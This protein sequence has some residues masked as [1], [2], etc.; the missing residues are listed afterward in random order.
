ML[1]M[2][3]FCKAVQ[4]IHITFDVVYNI[5]C[6][7]LAFSATDA[8]VLFKFA[9]ESGTRDLLLGQTVNQHI[10][11]PSRLFQYEGVFCSSTNGIISWLKCRTLINGCGG[12]IETAVRKQPLIESSFVITHHYLLPNAFVCA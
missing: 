5:Q 2:T 3:S 4:L 10:T 9:L 8:T 7:Q 12:G 11:L 1:L 6:R